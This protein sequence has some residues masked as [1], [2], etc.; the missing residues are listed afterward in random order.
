MS[1]ISPI[2]IQQLYELA[3]TPFSLHQFRQRWNEFGWH[4]Q[5]QS[6]DPFGFSVRVSVDQVLAVDPCG[7]DVICAFLP[8][9]YWEDYDLAQHQDRGE[10]QRQRRAYDAAYETTTDL[11][12]SVLTPSKLHWQDDDVEGHKAAAWPGAHGLLIL[13]QAAFDVQFGMEINFWL[14]RCSEDA[15]HP[16]TPLIDWLTRLSQ[17]EH[18]RRGFPPHSVDGRG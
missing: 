15:F 13:Q 14:T 4:Y 12:N 2:T 1:P 11:A 10:W 8:F 9:L 6:S 7:D 16:T 3:N 18:D 17:A 5:P